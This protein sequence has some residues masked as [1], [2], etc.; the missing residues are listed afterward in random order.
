MLDWCDGGT[1]AVRCDF[2]A[3]RKSEEDAGR[4]RNDGSEGRCSGCGI[5]V[6]T[7]RAGVEDTA[8][9]LVV[10]DCGGTEVDRRLWR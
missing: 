1:E 10:R 7:E 4:E 8:C 6:G 5:F 2:R 3:C 9:F